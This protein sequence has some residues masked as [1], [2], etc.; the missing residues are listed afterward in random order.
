M[1]L[2]GLKRVNVLARTYEKGSEDNTSLLRALFDNNRSL[3][4]KVST[5][6]KL[7]T[8]V[9]PKDFLRIK[10]FRPSFLDDQFELAKKPFGY[11]NE[12][13][14]FLLTSKIDP[15]KKFVLKVDY[16]NS[17]TELKKFSEGITLVRDFEGDPT[18]HVPMKYYFQCPNPFGRG[19]LTCSVSKLIE[20]DIGLVDIFDPANI[21]LVSEITRQHKYVL[22]ALQTLYEYLVRKEKL[23]EHLDIIGRQNVVLIYLN[24]Q[25][26][27]V[28]LDMDKVLTMH[29]KRRMRFDIRLANLKKII[30][31]AQDEIPRT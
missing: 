20:S 17:A 10:D 4:S 16:K 27:L 21:E 9:A 29:P 8:N 24:N 28:L 19:I 1:I 5:L 12:H 2:D 14:V 3:A 25:Y 26:K 6:V 31:N 13:A 18:I 22:L 7:I 30:D 11:G 15:E 23:G